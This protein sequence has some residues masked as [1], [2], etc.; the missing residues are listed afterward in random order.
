MREQDAEKMDM[1]D[2]R[3]EQ[4]KYVERVAKK[5]AGDNLPNNP[6]MVV[7]PGKKAPEAQKTVAGRR[8][9]GNNIE[10]ADRTDIPTID[11]KKYLV[12]SVRVEL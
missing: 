7:A 4:L 3:S 12:P 5:A 1:G 6:D 2:E 11:K 8:K 9:M 10:K